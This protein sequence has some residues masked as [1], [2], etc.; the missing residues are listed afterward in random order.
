MQIWSQTF[1]KAFDT[2]PP[3]VQD[4]IRLKIDEVGCN[5]NSFH[6]HRLGGRPEFRLRVG[7]YRVIYEF[8]ASAGRMFLHYVGHR[9]DIYRRS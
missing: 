5:L 6:H 2:L 9:R 1:C 4:A 8:D 3:S 7:D